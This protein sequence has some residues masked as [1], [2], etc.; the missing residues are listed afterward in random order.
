M[1]YQFYTKHW[2]SQNYFLKRQETKKEIAKTRHLLKI[3][4]NKKQKKK[5][6]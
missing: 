3:Y 4:K 5:E 6:I 1:Y 2:F